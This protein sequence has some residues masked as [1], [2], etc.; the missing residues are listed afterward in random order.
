[1]PLGGLGRDRDFQ[2]WFLPCGDFLEAY[3]GHDLWATFVKKLPR[4]KALELSSNISKKNTN[5]AHKSTAPWVPNGVWNGE[6]YVCG[7]KRAKNGNFLASG[8]EDITQ[9]GTRTL[10]ARFKALFCKQNFVV[11]TNFWLF[12]HFLQ[13]ISSNFLPD[14]YHNPRTLTKR[15]FWGVVV[16]PYSILRYPWL[17]QI[18]TEF[19]YLYCITAAIILQ[20][21]FK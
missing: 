15:G 16:P 9:S 11:K 10:A 18:Q 13:Q 17:L 8:F 20:T 1:M 14:L 21:L 19:L 6:T 4:W 7:S 3:N 5:V 12:N 2:F